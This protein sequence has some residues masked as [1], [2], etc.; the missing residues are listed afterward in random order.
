MTCW[1]LLVLCGVVSVMPAPSRSAALGPGV[2]DSRDGPQL[3]LDVARARAARSAAI[4]GD[5]VAMRLHMYEPF[6]NAALGETD[7]EGYYAIAI[8]ISVDSDRAFERL[9]YVHVRGDSADQ[10][11]LTPYAVMTRGKRLP[12]PDGS[13][14]SPRERFL[15]YALVRRPDASSIE[16]TIPAPLLP[17]PE[18]RRFRWQ[19]RAVSSREPGRVYYDYVPDDGLARGR[20]GK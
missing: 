3:V 11:G 8:G 4:T 14:F 18:S 17:L 10:D 6:T 1:K 15:G 13:A 2:A 20:A 12:E 5:Q 9:C 19:A 7:G 16:V